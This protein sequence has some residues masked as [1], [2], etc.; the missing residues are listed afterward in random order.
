MPYVH[1]T[2]ASHQATMRMHTGTLLMTVCSPFL[3]T[4]PHPC[5]RLHHPIGTFWLHLPSPQHNQLIL[6]FSSIDQISTPTRCAIV[7]PLNTAAG[8]AQSKPAPRSS[9]RQAARSLLTGSPLSSSAAP[10]HLCVC[11]CVCA[12]VCVEATGDQQMGQ[13]MKCSTR[14]EALAM[15][16]D[17]CHANGSRSTLA[18]PD[19]LGHPNTPHA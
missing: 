16:L 1:Q 7:T 12:C 15:T 18:P 5:H 13:K 14:S 4:P 6:R 11:V 9:G 17:A 8:K 2:R 19:T 10:S 3:R